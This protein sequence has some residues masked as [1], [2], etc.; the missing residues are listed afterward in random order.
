MA[1]SASPLGRVRTQALFAAFAP[2]LDGLLAV[3]LQAVPPLRGRLRLEQG[4]SFPWQH[5][6]ADDLQPLAVLIPANRAEA[7]HGAAITEPP[8]A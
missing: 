2:Q 3:Q 8:S 4:D 1:N 7:Q 5:L 6:A